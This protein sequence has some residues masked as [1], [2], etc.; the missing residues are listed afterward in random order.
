MFEK[1]TLKT[2]MH[3]I[4]F[5]SLMMLLVAVLSGFYGIRQLS[6]SLGQ[7][8]L[9]TSEVVRHNANFQYLFTRGHL[10]YEE[11]MA[12]D[13]TESHQEALDLMS[14]AMVELDSTRE[15]IDELGL[16]SSNYDK[17]MMHQKKSLE[18]A[19]VFYDIGKRAAEDPAFNKGFAGSETEGKF[20]VAFDDALNHADSLRFIVDAWIAQKVEADQTLKTQMNTMVWSSL[21][22]GFFILLIIPWLAQEVSRGIKSLLEQSTLL[23][24]AAKHGELEVRGNPLAV[25]LEFREI[26]HAMNTSLDTFLSPLQTAIQNL[27]MT[28]RGETAPE[29][30]SQWEGSFGNLQNSLNQLRTAQ[31]EISTIAQ[32]MA[33]GNLQIQVQSRS[34]EDALMHSLSKMV[35]QLRLMFGEIAQGVDTLAQSAHDL[36][37]VS[38]ILGESSQNTAK[39]SSAVAASA[40]EMSANAASVATNMS[41]ATLNLA[42]VSTATEEMSATIAEIASNSERARAITHDASHQADELSQMM[43]ELGA[44]AQQIGQVTETINNISAQ[45]N[46]L[47]L[48]A[49]IEAARAGSAGK[50]FAVVANEIKELARQTAQSTD[51]IKKK[52]QAIQTSTGSAVEEIIKIASVMRQVTHIVS[53]IATAVEE[54][55]VTTRDIANNIHFASEG[56]SG[57]NEGVIQTTRVLQTVAQDVATVHLAANEIRAA[58]HKVQEGS[59]VL[60]SLASQLRSQVQRFR[61]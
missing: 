7:M 16:E 27:E 43:Q 59:G 48:N 39:R 1:I 5:V 50:G 4:F 51:D 24:N 41:H 3:L 8:N 36:H 25:P 47:A 34:K 52:I 9:V 56:V 53:S 11:V 18:A 57:A 12:G 13:S 40:E 54:Q 10:L 14:T 29:I 6:Q 22:I 32:E 37:G 28:A 61:I 58:S 49:T 42:S 30:Q 45:T 33:S 35:S 26:I 19:K 44:S 46:L 38:D 17:A 23:A 55:T 15:F 60:N 31:L 2:K 20:D 21:A